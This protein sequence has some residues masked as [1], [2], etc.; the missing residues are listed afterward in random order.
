[1][2]KLAIEDLDFCQ[3]E[4]LE[5]GEVKGA[6]YSFSR[7]WK[8]LLFSRVGGPDGQEGYPV[9]VGIALAFGAA[10]AIGGR[11]ITGVNIQ[12]QSFEQKTP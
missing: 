4:F 11:P 12:I 3:R 2:S 9:Q 7:D 5:R 6:F 8:I 1:M 10:G